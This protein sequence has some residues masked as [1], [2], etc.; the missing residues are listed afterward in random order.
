[1]T[2]GPLHV[3][4]QR[5]K[6]HLLVQMEMEEVK[7][8]GLCC[9]QYHR[10]ACKDLEGNRREI[11][12]EWKVGVCKT[13]RCARGPAGGA[14]LEMDMETCMTDCPAGSEYLPVEGACCGRCSKP[15]ASR[16]AVSCHG[17]WKSLRRCVSC[18]TATP[19]QARSTSR[20]ARREGVRGVRGAAQRVWE[21]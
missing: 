12:Q 21:I 3:S 17:E 13:A 6:M 9:P 2:K 14:E 1:M 5:E 8:A 18:A 4:V 19:R 15:R 11:G 20:G 16:M 7:V 10:T